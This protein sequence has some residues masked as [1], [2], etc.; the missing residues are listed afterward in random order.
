[1]LRVCTNKLY[2]SIKNNTITI[3]VQC[4]CNIIFIFDLVNPLNTSSNKHIIMNI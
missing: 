3:L 4:F 1:M 2:Y